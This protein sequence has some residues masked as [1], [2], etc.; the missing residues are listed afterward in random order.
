[1][2]TLD[3]LNRLYTVWQEAELA[4]EAVHDN[5]NATSKMIADTLNN[6]TVAYEV[7]AALLDGYFKRGD[8]YEQT[9]LP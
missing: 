3:D 9:L 1:M 6:A 2:I 7:Y 5:P 4:V 8:T